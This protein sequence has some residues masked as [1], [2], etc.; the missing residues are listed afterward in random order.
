VVITH[1]HNGHPCAFESIDVW[2]LDTVLAPWIGRTVLAVVLGLL[3]TFL[4]AAAL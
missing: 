1:T 3:T 4:I 2:C